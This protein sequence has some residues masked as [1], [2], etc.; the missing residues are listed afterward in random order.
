MDNYR[1]GNGENKSD[2]YFLGA[3]F[4]C[5]ADLPL[6]NNFLEK[7][8]EVHVQYC[9]GETPPSLNVP[10]DELFRFRTKITELFDKSLINNVEFLL[11]LVSARTLGSTASRGFDKYQMQIAPDPGYELHHLHEATRTF[12]GSDASGTTISHCHPTPAVSSGYPGDYGR[13]TPSRR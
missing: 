9:L 4:S 3:G 13:H 8:K 10:M 1:D 11:S 12:P 5:G 6:S 7:M 2:V